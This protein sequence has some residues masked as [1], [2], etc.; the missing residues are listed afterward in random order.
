MDEYRVVIGCSLQQP[1]PNHFQPIFDD[2]S[3]IYDHRTNLQG[4]RVLLVERRSQIVCGLHE[5]R[6]NVTYH[7][8][9]T[10]QQS[11]IVLG[12]KFIEGLVK[13]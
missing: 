7:Q 2:E 8:D 6:D 3:M 9:I 10:V 12:Y 1:K 13:I 11:I 5:I 4:F